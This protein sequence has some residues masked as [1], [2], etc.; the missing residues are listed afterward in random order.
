MDIREHLLC[1]LNAKHRAGDGPDP[2][3]EISGGFPDNRRLEPDCILPAQYFGRLQ[4]SL[5]TGAE[6]RL[7]LAVLEDAIRCYMDNA[8]RT[9]RRALVQFREVSD[10]FN[11]RNCHDLFAFE[12]ICDFFGIDPGSLRR[13]LRI[14]SSDGKTGADTARSIW[15]RRSNGARDRVARLRR[16]LG[17]TSKARAG[18]HGPG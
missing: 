7:L 17:R 9:N 5:S 8:N 10:W 14:A 4:G 18:R 2:V 6:G 11:A 16:G 13:G 15:P 12:T 1:G 3:A